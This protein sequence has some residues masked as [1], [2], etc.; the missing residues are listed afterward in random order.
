M[1]YAAQ[2]LMQTNMAFNTK[3][4]ISELIATANVLLVAKYESLRYSPP[5]KIE[6]LLPI[7]CW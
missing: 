4:G 5:R 2:N 3:V 6:C 7:L 1:E